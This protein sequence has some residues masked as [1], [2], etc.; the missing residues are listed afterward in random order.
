MT[1]TLRRLRRVRATNQM[2]SG[3]QVMMMV[4]MP[5]AMNMMNPVMNPLMAM[6]GMGGSPMAMGGMPMGGLM[7]AGR[8]MQQQRP[9]QG[10]GRGRQARALAYAAPL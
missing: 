6:G 5:V 2:G 10:R 3:G 1:R 7:Q 4:P 8:G 9:Q